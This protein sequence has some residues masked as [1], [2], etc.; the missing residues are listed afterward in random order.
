MSPNNVISIILFYLT[1]TGKFDQEDMAVRTV[2]T[3]HLIDE[4]CKRKGLKVKET[5]V[6]FKHIGKA[7]LEEQVLIGGEE[8]G[9]LSIKGHIPEKD[10]LLA[11]LLLLEI[12]SYLKKNREGPY[13]SD[14]LSEIYNQFGTFYNLRLDLEIPT[15][16]EN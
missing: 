11:N 9:G 13:L 16:Q 12:Q 1:E 3:T 6:G 15:G 14:Y 2:A 4:I 10:G 7:M 5:P 8:S